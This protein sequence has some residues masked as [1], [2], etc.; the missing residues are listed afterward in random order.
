MKS[1]MN[2]EDLLGGEEIEYFFIKTNVGGEQH[3]FSHSSG[4]CFMK[5]RVKIFKKIGHAKAALKNA[6]NLVA[7]YRQPELK[8]RVDFLTEGIQNAV[9]VS[10]RFGVTTMDELPSTE[11]ERYKELATKAKQ[12]YEDRVANRHKM[13]SIS[14]PTTA[15]E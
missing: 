11:T 2:V 14:Y 4:L 6:T 15:G 12:S 13:F 3:Y 8:S 10:F 1:V 7:W 9:I 5:E